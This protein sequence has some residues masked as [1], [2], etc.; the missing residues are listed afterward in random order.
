M[1][2]SLL[3]QAL[4]PCLFCCC[5]RD[6]YSL[7]KLHSLL[8]LLTI[9]SQFDACSCPFDVCCCCLLHCW[10]WWKFDGN[11]V[12]TEYWC[13]WCSI[14]YI[15]DV[16]LWWKFAFRGILMMMHSV[17]LLLYFILWYCSFSVVDIFCSIH[18]NS[19]Y[20]LCWLLL[21]MTTLLLL[22]Y[23]CVLLLLLRCHAD[24]CCAVF[25]I[26][27]W[28]I[29]IL[30]LLST[31]FWLGILRCYSLLLLFSPFSG[32]H[33]S[34]CCCWWCCLHCWWHSLFIP[35]LWYIDDCWH[36]WYIDNFRY[37]DACIFSILLSILI[38]VVIHY[39]FR[40]LALFCTL[41]IDIWCSLFCYSDT[42]IP[43]CWYGH[44]VLLLI[45]DDHSWPHYSTLFSQ[46]LI[47]SDT[48]VLC[49]EHST[50]VNSMSRHW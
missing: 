28:P 18:W 45:V 31:N 10:C 2:I 32:V 39:P 9:L 43:I 34:R 38:D 30:L 35:L 23:S 4:T 24:I 36:I 22:R 19:Q 5:P 41:F 25:S 27:L 13:H 1:E 26:A 21:M 20:I 49:I 40:Y 12:G 48:F 42:Y 11:F 50:S 46:L 33:W 47:F 29:C 37:D 14:F 16:V 44:S 15:P 6:Y 3:L 8:L 17:P 7:Y